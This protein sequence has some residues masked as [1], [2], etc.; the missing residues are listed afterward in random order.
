M[1]TEHWSLAAM[2]RAHGVELIPYSQWSS[3]TVAARR[4]R[5]AAVSADDDTARLRARARRLG[6]RAPK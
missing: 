4:R 6:L 1:V 5:L 2:L 3:S